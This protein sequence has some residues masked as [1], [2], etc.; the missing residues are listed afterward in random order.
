MGVFQNGPTGSATSFIP[1]DYIS[2][3]RRAQRAARPGLENADDG[4]GRGAAFAAVRCRPQPAM[5][6][7]PRVRTRGSLAVST[8]DR[9][10]R[11]AI[12]DP[13]AAHLRHAYLLR[14]ARRLPA[15]RLKPGHHPAVISAS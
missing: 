8:A 7:A 11:K 3:G 2:I 14:A 4:A 15:P 1:M 6:L 5:R 10:I 9:T 13:L 12:E